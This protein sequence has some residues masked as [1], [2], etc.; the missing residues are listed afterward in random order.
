MKPQDKKIQS[1][2][3]LRDQTIETVK[4]N[5]KVNKHRNNRQYITKYQFIY[6]IFPVRSCE[7]KCA[8][9]RFMDSKI[10]QCY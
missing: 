9:K 10:P 2:E 3:R 6:F 5:M 7:E 8:S 4:I 1:H